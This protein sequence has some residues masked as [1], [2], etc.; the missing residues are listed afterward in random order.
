MTAGDLVSIESALGIKLPV[1]YRVAML[2]YPLG[3]AN[4]NSQIAL[5]ADAK[6]VNAF[7]R[8]LREQFP[9][10][11]QPGFFAVGNSPC[12][13]PYF[14]DL[15]S[16]SAAVWSWDHET[17]EVALVASDFGSWVAIQRL[18]EPG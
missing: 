17:H 10:E 6:T 9:S 2:A 15:A 12:G 7:N 11:W 8:F 5:L 1:M 13:D 4:A 18:P 3:P 14:L 16:D